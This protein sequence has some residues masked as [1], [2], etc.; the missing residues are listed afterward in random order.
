MCKIAWLVALFVLVLN[1]NIQA[2]NYI[3]YQNEITLAENLMF[4][5]LF[6]E[7]VHKYKSI[8]E[9]YSFN[10]PKDCLIAA[11]VAAIINDT[12]S[13]FYFMRKAVRFGAKNE[14]ITQ[15][16]LLQK[17]TSN[18]P[19]WNKYLKDYDTLCF[20]YRNS[21]DR[22]YKRLCDS[23]YQRDQEIRNIDQKFL[24]NRNVVWRRKLRKKWEN[25]CIR[26]LHVL[27]DS[28]TPT[29]G[30][31]S[32]RT[33]GVIDS[34][35]RENGNMRVSSV[36]TLILFYHFPKYVGKYLE[37]LYSELVLGNINAR[38]YAIALEFY[39]RNR[40]GFKDG[41]SSQYYIRWE[42]PPR[43][44]ERYPTEGEINKRRKA[45]GLSNCHYERIR[46]LWQHIYISGA[47]EAFDLFYYEF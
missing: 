24:N 44:S 37:L 12:S 32:Y 17:F 34:D 1:S 41:N 19:H 42:V 10:F 28:L 29:K 35:T 47:P 39:N 22:E 25:N 8:F 36:Q 9:R 40:K 27:I 23:F 38:D 18:T 14:R 15:I 33:I 11:Q 4:D 20:I 46:K 45:I 7:S 26:G 21:I 31:P 30:F 13:T 6:Y 43:P 16:R 2:E 5:S 3:E